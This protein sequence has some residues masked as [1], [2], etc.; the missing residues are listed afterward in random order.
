MGKGRESR[1]DIAFAAGVQGENLQPEGPSRHSRVS[2]LRL[3]RRRGR[4]DEYA[5]H[6]GLWHY[7]AQE[8]QLLGLQVGAGE[9][10][11]AGD[12]ASGPVESC[13]EAN[14]HRVVAGREHDGNRRSCRLG[15]VRCRLAVKNPKV[16][17]FAPGSL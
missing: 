10:G 13:H 17:L 8:F 5:N 9:E 11:N 2:F 15:R 16:W 4:V 7:L 14:L 12:I 3:G 1:V 6:A